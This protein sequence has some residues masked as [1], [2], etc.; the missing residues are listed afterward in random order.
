VKDA[1]GNYNLFNYDAKGNL[2]N[3]IRLTKAY[4]TTNNC[5]TLNP[6][7]YVP[8]ATDIIAW[9][10]N[11]YDA[12]GNR[13]TTKL[14]RDF[15]GQV[16]SPTAISATGAIITRTYDANSLYPTAIAR[17]GKKNSDT[18]ATTQTVTLVYDTLGRQTS[19]IDADWH[20]T[21]FN[22][23][24]A[25]HVIKGTDAL[26]NLRSYQYD[27]NDNPSGERL[28]IAGSLFDSRS[29]S[30]DLND[31]KQTSV[32]AGGNVTAYQYDAAGNVVLVTNPDAYT[33]S[34]EYDPSNHETRRFDAQNHAVTRSLDSEGK[35]RVITDPNGNAITTAYYD[36]TGDGRLK[37]IT[38]AGKHQ[39][40]LVYDA[41]GNATTVTVT[42]SDAITTRTTSTF[43]DEL[44]HPL[45]IV[46]PQYTDA[47]LGAI[48]PVTQ[49]IYDTLGNRTQ[50]LAG[51]TTDATG[52]NAALDVLKQQTTVVWDDF[53]RKVKETDPLNQAWTYTYDANNN[54]VTAL[55]PLLQTTTLTWVTATS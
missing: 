7:T 47:T 41:N 25:D 36:A 2:T 14:V 11:G 40:S 19:G 20:V 6:T 38:D 29:V 22:Y 28:D 44:D 52:T 55:D 46:G 48:R 30:Y 53:G 32:D 31:R 49:Y 18:T 45:R 3:E 42:G 8:A 35:P 4:C 5:A 51:Y 26:G 33:L 12:Y 39:T 23:D 9:R 13:V 16:A 54:L 21:Q 43:Y 10:V 1:N 50:V 15:V 27:A 34:L 17:T 37:S 24:D